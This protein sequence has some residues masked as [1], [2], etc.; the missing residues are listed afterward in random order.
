MRALKTHITNPR[1]FQRLCVYTEL[2]IPTLSNVR[3]NFQALCYYWQKSDIHWSQESVVFFTLTR[4]KCYL[5]GL[6]SAL[7][8]LD[9]NNCSKMYTDNGCSCFHCEFRYQ[10]FHGLTSVGKEGCQFS[11][12]FHEALRRIAT[13]VATHYPSQ[14]AARSINYFACDDS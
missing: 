3:T 14:L 9:F 6:C 5:F 4:L 11:G 2:W 13:R 8:T 7:S 10:E 1:V 12:R